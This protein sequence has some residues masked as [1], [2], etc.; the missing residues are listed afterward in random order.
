[1]YLPV[2][3]DKI[4]NLDYEVFLSF[5]AT[6]LED[7]NKESKSNFKDR[8]AIFKHYKKNNA[9]IVP[10]LEKYFAK[11]MKGFKYV[12]DSLYWGNRL[13]GKEIFETF[14]LYCGIAMGVISIEEIKLQITDNMD[15]YEKKRILLEKK[16]RKTKQNNENA[17]NSTAF[18]LIMTGVCKE[19]NYTYHD[20]LDMT[21]YSIYYMYSLLGSIMNYEVSNIAAGNGLLKR[22]ATHNHWATQRLKT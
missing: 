2:L 7:I 22:S 10:I 19:F 3:R 18:E 1:M 11:Y 17:N 20:L 14:C 16:I 12:D 21:I 8:Y 5:C 13:V 6:S 4:E 15:E 9:D